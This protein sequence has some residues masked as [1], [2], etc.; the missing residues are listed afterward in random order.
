MGCIVDI[1]A[2]LAILRSYGYGANA[3]EAVEKIT[4]DEKD[5]CKCSCFTF[6]F[7]QPQHINAVYF[8]DR[9][10]KVKYIAYLHET[11]LT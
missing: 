9:A 7:G 10:I 11:L 8:P 6:Q 3:S 5:H 2:V 1:M 4:K